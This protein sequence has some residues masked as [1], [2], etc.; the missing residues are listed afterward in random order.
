MLSLTPPKSAKVKPG[1]TES[2]R[3]RPA[4]S[5]SNA[6]ATCSIAD[7]T[8]ELTTSQIFQNAGDADRGVG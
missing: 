6:R 1:R 3:E 2:G 5:F 8:E 4:R 7:E